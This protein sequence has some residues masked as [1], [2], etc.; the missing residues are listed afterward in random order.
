MAL[1]N[2]CGI[3]FPFFGYDLYVFSLLGGSSIL[4][5]AFLYLTLYAF[6]CSTYY[7]VFLH[8]IVV[9]EFLAWIDYLYG[10]PISDRELVALYITIICIFSF[11]ILFLR[12]Q[13][14][15]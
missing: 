15:Q 9:T 5:L 13:E 12:F 1:C 6:H 4:P 3:I 2:V 7:R 10:I 11:I 14:S 8:Y